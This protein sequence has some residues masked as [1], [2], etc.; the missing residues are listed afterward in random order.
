MGAT[1]FTITNS[2]ETYRLTILFKPY[3]IEITKTWYRVKFRVLIINDLWIL[4]LSKTW[5]RARFRV[6]IINDLWI[7]VLSVMCPFAW[8]VFGAC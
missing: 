4:D 1:D 7:L 2:A 8:A 3:F 6:L 5:Y